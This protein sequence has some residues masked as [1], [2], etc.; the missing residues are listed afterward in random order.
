MEILIIKGCR[1]SGLRKWLAQQQ[2]S[3]D[4]ACYKKNEKNKKNGAVGGI[5]H[6][7]DN[8]DETETMEHVLAVI[9]SNSNATKC[10]GSFEPT[11]EN[12]DN[13]DPGE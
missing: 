13:E 6:G 1:Y 11:Q 12:F 8:E 5:V 4:T 2:L 7:T 10:H 3:P 9:Y